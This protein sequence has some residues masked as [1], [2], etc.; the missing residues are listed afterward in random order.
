M[1]LFTTQPWIQRQ[2][3]LA[4]KTDDLKPPATDLNQ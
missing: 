1:G 3:T 4:Q 2:K